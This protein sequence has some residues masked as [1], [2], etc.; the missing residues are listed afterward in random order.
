MIPTMLAFTADDHWE[1]GIGDPTVIGWVT[2]VAYF[3][4][5][6]LSWRAARRSPKLAATWSGPRLFW[7]LFTMA[8]VLLGINKQLDL[9]T[10]FTLFFKQVALHE[11]WYERRRPVQAAFIGAVAVGGIAS[12]AG[13][14]VLAR[15]W[16]RPIRMALIGGIF[17]GCFIL[18]RASSFHHVDQ[19]LGMDFEGIKVNWMLELGGIAF[20]GM[21][22]W[23]AGR[24]PATAAARPGTPNFIWVTA[25]DRLK[26][27]DPL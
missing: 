1:P 14:K 20:V 18:I 16:T 27:P 3:V 21:A 12:L 5:A 19:M 10:W 13:M 11:G 23:R 15:Q 7:Q 24:R 22:A 25:G 2:V 26:K 8:L 9:Q 6:C 17:L 4:A